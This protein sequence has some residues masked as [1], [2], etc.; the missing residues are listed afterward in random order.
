[1]SNTSADRSLGE[2]FA[3]LSRKTTLLVRQ[4]LEL[5]KTEMTE[6]ATEAGKNIGFLIA[7]GAVLYM[8]LLFILAAVAIL[9]ATVIPDWL[10][11]LIVGL[12]V[13]VIGLVLVQRGRAALKQ[14]T[15][16][17]EKTI[18][19]LKEDKEWVQQQVK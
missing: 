6:K 9:L 10:A 17:P 1:M 15:L 5:A 18:E 11:A 12:V 7:G 8:G 14:T 4:E 3:D 13:A 19:S 16:K 2:L